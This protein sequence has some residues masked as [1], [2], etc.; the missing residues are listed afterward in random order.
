M[1]FRKARYCNGFPNIHC[2]IKRLP[3]SNVSMP[4]RAFPSIPA[5]SVTKFTTVVTRMK[6]EGVGSCL[7]VSNGVG[8]QL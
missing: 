5:D 3:H 7:Y 6:V 2:N 1:D 4:S 8:G